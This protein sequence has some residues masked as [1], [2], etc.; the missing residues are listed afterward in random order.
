MELSAA[1]RL[2]QT[3]DL[4]VDLALAACRVASRHGFKGAFIDLE[5]DVWDAHQATRN[6]NS[7]TVAQGRSLLAEST[8]R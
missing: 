7:Q 2:P 6:W 1:P 8:V 3:D 4:L 5:L